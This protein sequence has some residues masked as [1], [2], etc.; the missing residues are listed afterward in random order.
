MAIGTAL[1]ALQFGGALLQRFSG[2]QNNPEHEANVRRVKEIDRKNQEIKGNNLTIGANY[3]RAKVGAIEQ[4]SNERLAGA[5]DRSRARL[6]LDRAARGAALENQSG[7]IK[8]MRNQNVG[9]GKMDLSRAA[10]QQ[11]G[12]NSSARLAKLTDANDDFITGTYNRNMLEQNRIK[13]AKQK[14]AIKPQ[15]Q[16]YITSYTPQKSN[17]T[18]KML[19]FAGGVLGD[20]AGAAGTFDKFKPRTDLDKFDPQGGKLFDLNTNFYQK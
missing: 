12:R 3:R 1:A 15:Y 20:I 10:V 16:Q 13:L 7:F 2:L 8:M 5:Q 9:S 18:A 6:S 11:I 19:G 4:I 17:Q 14:V